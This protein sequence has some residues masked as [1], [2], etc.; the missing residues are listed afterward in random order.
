MF[1]E[2][3]LSEYLEK[4]FLAGLEINALLVAHLS[5][6]GESLKKALKFANVDVNDWFEMACDRGMWRN[7]VDRVS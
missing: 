3:A 2:W 4:C 1:V 5:P 7:V 6:M